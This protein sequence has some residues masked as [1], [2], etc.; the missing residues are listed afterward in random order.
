MCVFIQ[1]GLTALMIATNRQKKKVVEALL[2]SKTIDV[3][4]PQKV[5]I[6]YIFLISGGVRFK[7]LYDDKPK[8]VH[9]LWFLKLFIAHRTHSFLLC[10]FL[11]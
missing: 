11:L 8:M 7:L 5:K 1:V 3:N 10:S 9:F 2:E 6:T 4:I